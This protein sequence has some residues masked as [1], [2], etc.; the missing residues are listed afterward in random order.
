MSTSIAKGSDRER[1][2]LLVEAERDPPAVRALEAEQP[3]TAEV[4]LEARLAGRPAGGRAHL[5]MREAPDAL[6][7][8]PGRAE[9]QRLAVEAPV[10]ELHPVAH[11]PRPQLVRAGGEPVQ[12]LLDAQGH[13]GRSSR[14]GMGLNRVGQSPGARRSMPSKRSSSSGGA[15]WRRAHASSAAGAG[16]GP[17]CSAKTKA[18]AP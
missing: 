16:G 6:A 13:A 1:P 18:W 7:G 12:A 8:R 4:E 11:E 9:R 5:G 15:A 17:A 2:V 14:R 3:L 10:A